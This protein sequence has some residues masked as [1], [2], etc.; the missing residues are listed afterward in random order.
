MATRST[1]A[2]SIAM[3]TTAVLSQLPPVNSLKGTACR[4]RTANL[5]GRVRIRPQI[6]PLTFLKIF[7]LEKIYSGRSQHSE[8]S[9]AISNTSLYYWG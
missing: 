5:K 6:D 1:V 9:Y 2:T 7:V 8:P 3:A 4:Q